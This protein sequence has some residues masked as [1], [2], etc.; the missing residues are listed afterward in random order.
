MISLFLR[1]V[2]IIA[3]ATL[4]AVGITRVMLDASPDDT[5]LEILRGHVK[6]HADDL[7]H[8]PPAERRA[9]SAKLAK[10]LGYPVQLEPSTGSPEPRTERRLQELFVVAHIP[11]TEGQIAIGPVPFGAVAGWHV[12]LAL[13]L[14]LALILAVAATVPLLGRIRALENVAGKM[15]DGDFKARMDRHEGDAFDGISDSLNQL[16]DRIGN[17]LRDE[18]DLLRTVAHEARAPIA[19]MRFRVESIQSKA[20][21]ASQKNSRGLISDLSQ[22]DTLFEEL[23]TYVA[24]DEFDQERPELQLTTLNV[25]DAVQRVAD[26]VTDADDSTRIEL[27]GDE[28]CEVTANLKLFKRAVTNL[29]LN[30]INYGGPILHIE[31]RTFENNCVV[32]VQDSGPGIPEMDRPEVVKPFVRLSKKKTRGT[33][34]G[35]AIVSRIMRLHGGELHIVDAPKG[36]ASVQLVWQRA[37]TDK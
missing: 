30:A 9:H 25:K 7:A 28:A 27:V 4:L 13:C 6:L 8:T 15:H 10:T 33:G 18:R 1:A 12:V 32:D 23:L 34:L 5:A 37:R 31:I 36:G 24:F 17:L 2:S 22:I 3:L 11:G 21:E 35:L 14:V 16:A 19:R 20:D 29:L 26:E